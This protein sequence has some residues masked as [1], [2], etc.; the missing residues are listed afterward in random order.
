MEEYIG[1]LWDK[2]V[3]RVAY[4]GFPEAR[5]ELRQMER[6]A[7]IFF[8]ALGGDPGLNV[9]SGTATEHGARRGL[10]ERIA[11]IGERVELAWADDNTLHLPAYIETFPDSELNRELYL[12]LIALAAHDVAPDAP[13]IAR[14]QQ[15]TQATLRKLPGLEPRYQKR[16]RPASR[17][18]PIRPR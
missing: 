8:R 2:L 15:A 17:C 1:G 13:W 12:W 10:L 11:G 7:P 4:R 9:Q 5:I 16:S 6:I 18:G 3:T 14:N